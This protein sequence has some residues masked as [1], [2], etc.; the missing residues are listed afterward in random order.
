M[1]GIYSHVR[2]RAK[3]KALEA[4]SSGGPGD[5]YDT[6]RDTNSPADS[7]HGPQVIENN[8]GREGIRTLGLLVANEETLKLRRF[9]TIS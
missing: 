4:L 7:K 1:L 6:N 2:I 3:R 9:A 8:D 5:G